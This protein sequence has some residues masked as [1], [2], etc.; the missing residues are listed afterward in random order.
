MPVAVSAVSDH[1][2]VTFLLSEGV[3]DAATLG[4]KDRA[5]W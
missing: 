3:A 4:I 5:L 2:P 1:S